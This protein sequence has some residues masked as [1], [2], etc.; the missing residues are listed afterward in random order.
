MDKSHTQSINDSLYPG[1]LL[2]GR[3]RIS[4]KIGQ[5]GMGEVYLAQD[6]LIGNRKVAIKLLHSGATSSI[7]VL[8]LRH[9]KILKEAL[10][11]A[12]LDHPN[13]VKVFDVQQ[14]GSDSQ[15]SERL[16]GA[17]YMVM[18][19]VEG[20]TLF[21]QLRDQRPLST[22]EEAL[23]HWRK[24][25]LSVEHAHARGVIHRDLKP[26]NIIISAHGPKVLDFGISQANER[27]TEEGE[28]P[29]P[30][31]TPSYMRPEAVQAMERNERIVAD[32]RDDVY[33][34]G[35]ILYQMLS[36]GLDHPL[37]HERRKVTAYL[38]L[39]DRGRFPETW[40]RKSCDSLIVQALGLHPGCEIADGT[41][42]LQA[43]ELLLAGWK[44]FQEE[45][46]ERSARAQAEQQ[47]RNQ[48]A[49]HTEEKRA[50]DAQHRRTRRHWLIATAGL[51]ALMFWGS[52]F[53]FSFLESR[54]DE[55]ELLELCR[56]TVSREKQDGFSG[57]SMLNFLKKAG[58]RIVKGQSLPAS[59]VQLFNHAMLTPFG[60]SY[61][62]KAELILD[63]DAPPPWMT[64]HLGQLRSLAVSPDGK[65]I[66]GGGDRGTFVIAHIEADLHRGGRIVRP[67]LG[68]LDVEDNVP[69]KPIALL[70]DGASL[71]VAQDAR[72]DAWLYEVSSGAL[73]EKL[74]MPLKRG[75]R[76]AITAIGVGRTIQEALIATRDD[77]IFSWSTSQPSKEPV[78]IVATTEEPVHYLT[79]L[80]DRSIMGAGASKVRIWK[81][82]MQLAQ[83]PLHVLRMIPHQRAAPTLLVKE[84]RGLLFWRVDSEKLQNF[85][86]ELDASACPLKE[87]LADTMDSTEFLR[88]GA[89]TV[90][91]PI[92]TYMR[93]CYR[94]LCQQ[95]Q[96]N[97]TDNELA[98]AACLPLERLN[99]EG[100]FDFFGNKK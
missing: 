75:K 92:P 13:I 37:E 31:G 30:S 21:Q 29:S 10:T 60:L 36:L 66:A 96:S 58:A 51:V 48:E 68:H 17:Y 72:S 50:T 85:T 97:S 11:T 46:A 7:P 40:L 80:T 39:P 49:R 67:V 1:Q 9:A 35:I 24:L 20:H 26:G 76:P 47:M 70:A 8:D 99:P 33:A 43:C 69:I 98:H 45:Q 56:T 2:S 34:L 62:D 19:F 89:D 90:P 16:H 95:L 59:C 87:V 5:G 81:D 32:K 94:S 23:K 25:V 4:H 93:S 78:N 82:G 77:G 83:V 57:G 41:A 88:S 27:M 38:E 64:E 22:V 3:Y 6:G 65:V 79:T 42:L 91:Q 100:L 55:Q 52:V 63:E 14:I 54:K 12:A 84:E 18:E 74:R 44:R 53:L 61:T 73:K 86:K 15:V 28:F 71:I